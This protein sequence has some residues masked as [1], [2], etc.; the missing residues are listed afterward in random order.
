MGRRS[1]EMQ[2]PAIKKQSI[3]NFLKDENLRQAVKNKWENFRSGH[4]CLMSFSIKDGLDIRVEW[5]EK[6][7]TELLNN[8]AKVIRISA[9][10]KQ[11]QNKKVAKAR[12]NWA[13]TKRDVGRD[14]TQ[15]QELKQNRNLSYQIIRKVK[16][17]SWQNFLQKKTIISASKVKV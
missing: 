12:S 4:N 17:L 1:S 2:Q 8:H 5:F 3:Q 13:K 11:W 15:K 7:V 16:R 10:F 6:S 9:Y 14:E